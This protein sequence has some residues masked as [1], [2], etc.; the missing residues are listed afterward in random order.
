ML[1]TARKKERKKKHILCVYKATYRSEWAS[2]ALRTVVSWNSQTVWPAWVCHLHHF[3][4]N[5]NTI[6]SHFPQSPV[7]GWLQW[8]GTCIGA[9]NT[10][11]HNSISAFSN[12]VSQ[13]S[14][15]N[16]TLIEKVVKRIAQI[17]FLIALS[18]QK[19]FALWSVS[20]QRRFK[21]ALV[22]FSHHYII[23]T[24]TFTSH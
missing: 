12:A 18:S 10:H 21:W 14:E 11:M 17:L 23:L 6:L 24:E 8:K 7:F 15:R 5:F 16:W 19:V 13:A 1:T 2:I 3:W 4:L 20:I 22:H 9:L